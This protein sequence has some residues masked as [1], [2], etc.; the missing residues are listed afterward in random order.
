MRGIKKLEENVWGWAIDR[1]GDEYS[2]YVYSFPDEQGE[3]ECIANLKA[4]TLGELG[5]EI[6]KLKV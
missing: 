5:E 6:S 3:S 4:K 1:M 2:C